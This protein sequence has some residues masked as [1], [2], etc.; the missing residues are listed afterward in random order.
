MK[1][2]TEKLMHAVFCKRQVLL[3]K[4]RQIILDKSLPLLSK[5]CIAVF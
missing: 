2:N 1:I 5:D 4:F 3:E